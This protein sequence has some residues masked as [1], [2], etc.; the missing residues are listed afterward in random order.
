M[1]KNLRLLLSLFCALC[2]LLSPGLPAALAAEGSLRYVVLG[3]SIGYGAGVLNP[4][5]ACYGRIVADTNGYDYQNH[6]VSGNRTDH[7]LRHLKRSEV[8]A[9]VQQA[10]IISISIGGNDYLTDNVTGLVLDATL[11]NDYSRMDK[12]T[13]R[14]KENFAAIIGKI[15]DL[16]PDAVI[17]MQT[18]YNPG[19]GINKAP[20]QAAVN[21]LNDLIRAYLA[22]HPGA[23]TIVDVAAAFGTDRSYIAQ[24]SIHPSARGNERIA[25]VIL[26]ALKQLGLGTKT[27]PVVLHKGVD[28]SDRSLAA[29]PLRLQMFRY[30]FA[31]LRVYCTMPE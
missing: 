17:L 10:D 15:R 30:L 27:E 5:E 18:L 28:Q 14:L 8:A 2:V 1:K 3:D 21:R 4:D 31:L 19:T 25:Q 29:L 20:Y 23:F 7:L 12:I 13:A 9:A 22:A 24:D 26:R 6:A 11:C 16:N